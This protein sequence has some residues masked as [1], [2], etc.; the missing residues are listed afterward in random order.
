MTCDDLAYICIQNIRPQAQV[1][2]SSDVL[3]QRLSTGR[4]E[5]TTQVNQRE[6]S[7]NPTRG[8]NGS[9]CEDSDL[10]LTVSDADI[11]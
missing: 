8:C 2:E 10:L 11:D 4:E 9:V 3:L 5:G 7:H 1:F 6:A